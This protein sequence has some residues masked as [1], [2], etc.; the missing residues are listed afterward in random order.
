MDRRDFIQSAAG[1]MLVAAAERSRAQ[2]ADPTAKDKMIGMQV[3]AVS[4]VDEGTEKVLDELQQDAS[5]NTL[6]VATFTYG[7]GI[8]TAVQIPGQPANPPRKK[9]YDTDTFAWRKLHRDSSAVLQEHG[10]QGLPRS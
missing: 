6:F 1:G 10:V 3:G 2:K 4:F 8:A 9:E 7:R 5:V